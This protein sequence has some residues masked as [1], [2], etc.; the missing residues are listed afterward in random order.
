MNCVRGDSVHG[1]V[2]R[3]VCAKF[4]GFV[5]GWKGEDNFDFVAVNVEGKDVQRKS[6]KLFTLNLLPFHIYSR[7]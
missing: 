5:L 4:L 1:D 6:F 2:S 3:I 7:N